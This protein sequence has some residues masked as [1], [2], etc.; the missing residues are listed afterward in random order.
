MN[1]DP[2]ISDILIVQ[3]DYNDPDTYIPGITE[4]VDPADLC[5]HSDIGYDCECT[6]KPPV[7]PFTRKPTFE[8]CPDYVDYGRDVA[9]FESIEVSYGYDNVDGNGWTPIPD[10]Y[11]GYWIYLDQP[12]LWGYGDW[13]EWQF[14][15]KIRD[16]NNAM[17]DWCPVAGVNELTEEGDYVY[18]YIFKIPDMDTSEGDIE[19]G[20]CFTP[21]YYDGTLLHGGY[22]PTMAEQYDAH[23]FCIGVPYLAGVDFY[24][25]IIGILFEWADADGDDCANYDE[26]VGIIQWANTA[27]DDEITGA[28]T[29]TFGMCDADGTGTLTWAE[30]NACL[31]GAGADD[32][33]ATMMRVLFQ[34]FDVMAEEEGTFDYRLTVD[35][36][37]AGVNG[38]KNYVRD[39]LSEFNFYWHY[40]DLSMDECI[41]LPEFEEGLGKV[42]EVTTETITTFWINYYLTTY[43][44]TEYWWWVYHLPNGG[45]DWD[46][47]NRRVADGPALDGNIYFYQNEDSSV[48][49]AY[50][51]FL[52]N[53]CYFSLDTFDNAD[54]ARSGECAIPGH[55]TLTYPYDLS[56]ITFNFANNPSHS[57]EMIWEMGEWGPT[58]EHTDMRFYY[59]GNMDYGESWLWERTDE[60]C[61]AC[62]SGDA[63]YPDQSY[64]ADNTIYS[65]Q[66]EYAIDL[67][68][69]VISGEGSSTTTYTDVDV[70]VG[71]ETTTETTVTTTDLDTGE[72]TSEVV[73][74]GSLYDDDGYY[75]GYYY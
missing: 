61:A 65:Y 14:G 12:T 10:G 25:T 20:D 46:G 35:E 16:D 32:D 69:T 54:P 70:D 1:D 24:S 55:K 71:S 22:N 5:D 43:Q 52:N 36:M 49:L 44:I 66:E 60:Y 21:V 74:D 17:V 57:V 47:Y 27:A 39:L 4:A 8:G 51:W 6:R 41:S 37:I 62:D 29:T 38:I 53:Q 28:I 33:T 31:E 56:H 3:A 63:G 64:W 7:D 19:I 15:V 67:P 18:R 72:V 73:D 23:D 11:W 68:D 42:T 58:G 9:A 40:F 2:S 48:S 59:P 34:Y 50:M 75:G 45:F 13:E 26:F 30:L